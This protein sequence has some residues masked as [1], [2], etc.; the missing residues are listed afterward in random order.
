MKA[1]KIAA[2]PYR[3]QKRP[4]YK[5]VLDLR[6]YSKGRIFFTTKSEAEQEEYRQKVLL[7]RQG[8]AALGLSQRKLA[9]LITA[10]ERL[11]EYGKTVSEAADFLIHHEEK[12]R[13]CNVTVR[14][15]TEEVLTAKQRDGLSERYLESLRGYLGKFCR[16]FGERLIAAIT[17]EELDSWLRNL[18]Y[19]SPKSR[20]NF[21][22]HIGVLFS[23]AKQRRMIAENP[24]EFTSRPKLVDKPVG[25]LTVEETRALLEAAQRL[26]PAVV[27]MLALA[28]FC[29]ARDSE[30]HRLEWSNVKLAQGFIEIP[31]AKAKSARRRLIPIQPNLREWIQPHSCMSGHVV[32]DGYRG[33]VGRA[34]KAAGI[35]AWPHNALRHSFASYR[36]AATNDAPRTALDLGHTSPQIL[37]QHY[38]E[39]VT[40]EEGQRYFDIRPAPESSNVVTFSKEGQA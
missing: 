38:R 37:F 31:A 1:A 26:E 23:H 21:R 8:D 7:Q 2:R 34:R 5:W 19:Y 30:V 17:P 6:A 24:I 33:M 40:P 3:D 20:L 36:L 15:L 29:G 32:P 18:P 14:Q 10:K 12:I 22:Q 28:A 11:A 39:V 4:R 27:P 35:S 13:R 25:I 9:D 16:A